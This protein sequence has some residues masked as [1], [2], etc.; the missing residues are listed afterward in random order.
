MRVWVTADPHFNHNNIIEL[1][2]RPFENVQEM[3]EAILNRWHRLVAPDDVVYLVG[4]LCFKKGDQDFNYWLRKLKGEVRFIKGNH[5]SRSKT[6]W[7]PETVILNELGMRLILVHDPED[8]IFDNGWV[9]HGHLHEQGKLIDWDNRRACISM[10][11]TNFEPVDLE[12]LVKR[13]AKGRGGI[14]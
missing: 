6:R 11:L 10:D 9:I 13:L 7:I 8:Y 3:N 5:D 14:L 2:N 1:C 4:D 12:L